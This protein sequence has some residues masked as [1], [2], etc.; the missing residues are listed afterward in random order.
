[1]GWETRRG[2]GRYYT[3]SRRVGRRVVRTYVG[4]GLLAE[5]AAA[6]DALR[7]AQRQAQREAREAERQR[8]EEAAGPLNGLGALTDLV[9]RATLLSAGCYQH[10]GGEWRRRGGTKGRNEASEEM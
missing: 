2:Q 1:M 5:Q 4:T 10:D 9:M 8:H 6:E 3:R 7:Q